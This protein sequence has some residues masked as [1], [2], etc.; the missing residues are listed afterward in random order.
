M[1]ENNSKN[2]IISGMFWKLGERLLS[3]GVSFVISVILARLLVPDDYGLIALIMVFIN[4]ANVFVVSGFSTA[5]I[6]KKDA[7]ETDFSTIFYCVQLCSILLF[8]IL[9]FAAPL[10]SQF[11]ERNELTLLLRVFAIIVPLSAYNSVQVAYVSRHMLFHKIF[12]ASIISAAVSGGIGIGLAYLGWGVWALVA[13][14]IAATLINTLVMAIT[15]PWRPCLKFSAASAKSLMK[16]GSRVLFADLSGTFFGELRSLIIGRVYTSAD[17]A[18]YSKGQQIPTLLTN[19]LGNAIMTVMF[20]ALANQSDDLEQVKQMAKR[21]M[22]VLSYIL[23]PC[24]F[25]LAAVMKPLVLVLFTEKWAQTIPYGQILCVGYCIGIFS[26]I[27]LQVLKAI[28]RSDVVLK[29]EIWKKP[30]YVILLIVGVQ[31]NVFAVAVTMV[32]YDIYGFF[33]NMIQM[34][35]YINYNLREQFRDLFPAFSLGIVMAAG[36]LLIPTFD[37]LILT[38]IVKVLAGVVVYVGGSVLFKVETL[39][40]LVAMIKEKI[41]K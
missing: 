35:K 33:V 6:Q 2:S 21:S 37:S 32:L 26:I 5:L 25:G 39:Q 19:N 28:G 30:I 40:Y 8:V 36:V 31:I 20:P 1:S 15:V 11:Y 24:M 13:Q 7:D 23:V 38:L 12:Y 18:F 41:K 27:S 29:L 16:Y 10:V 22:R 34:R 4:L 3:Q 9:F 17:L 14:T